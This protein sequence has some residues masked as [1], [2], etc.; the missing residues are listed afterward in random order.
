MREG[1]DGGMIL[2]FSGHICIM[3][4]K[5][6]SGERKNELTDQTHLCAVQHYELGT[7]L[8]S[9][10]GRIFLLLRI[11]YTTPGWASYFFFYLGKVLLVHVKGS[12]NCNS[13]EKKHFPNPLS[14][15][16][17]NRTSCSE[18]N[19]WNNLHAF[20]CIPP[21]LLQSACAFLPKREGIFHSQAPLK[22]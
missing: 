21:S 9:T 1:E 16:T 13:W 22:Y 4:D 10:L 7:M 6:D 5:W 18:R 2:F 19:T 15:N 8:L 11:L 12:F 3:E 20:D 17:K 14:S